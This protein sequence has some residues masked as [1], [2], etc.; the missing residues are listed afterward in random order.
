MP[1]TYEPI[2]TTTLAS[3]VDNVTFTSIPTTYTDLVVVVSGGL[4]TLTNVSCITLNGDNGGNYSYTAL[5]GN[6][7]VASSDR[8]NN[9]VYSYGANF[10][11]GRGVFIW[12]I[13]NYANTN[14]FKSILHR[15]NDVSNQIAAIISVWRNTSA[16]STVRVD[17]GGARLFSINTSFTLYGITAA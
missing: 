1:V 11:T 3:T 10:T 6:G 15:G 8:A 9:A 4:N 12:H 5:R 13:M 2:A 7:T 14:V 17:S 16:I